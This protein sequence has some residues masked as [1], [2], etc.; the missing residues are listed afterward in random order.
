M[1][2]ADTALAQGQAVLLANAG[3]TVTFRGL[4]V[5]AVVNLTAY[6]DKGERGIPDLSVRQTSR[7]EIPV[8]AVASEPKASEIITTTG[9]RY[10]RIEV[11][12][13][14][15]LGWLCDCEVST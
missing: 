7:I 14:T 11:V 6:P 10:H 4:S 5:S 13:F 8:G 3:D 15:G 9:P 2:A 12:T 1:N